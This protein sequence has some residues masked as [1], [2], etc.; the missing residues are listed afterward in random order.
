MDKLRETTYKII[1]NKISEVLPL[2]VT[3]FI[4][5]IICLISIIS[6]ETIWDLKAYATYFICGTSWRIVV[7]MN[8]IRSLVVF[9]FG[10]GFMSVISLLSRNFIVNQGLVVAVG[11]RQMLLMLGLMVIFCLAFCL[12]PLVVIGRK[13]PVDVFRNSAE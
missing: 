7:G 9:I 5:T 8:A 1:N 3:I 11:S 13:K 6:I 4:M 10:L 2:F 12:A